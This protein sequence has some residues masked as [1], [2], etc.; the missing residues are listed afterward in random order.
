MVGAIGSSV[1]A[2]ASVS[3]YL[4]AGTA[5]ARAPAGGAGAAL[6]GGSGANGKPLSTADQTLLDKLKARDADVK[7]H[8]QAHRSAGGQYTGAPT[9]TYQKGPDGAN[10]AIGGEV[11]IDTSPVTRDPAATV[12][13]EEQVQRAALAPADPS[14]QDV[15][16]AAEAAAAIAQAEASKV[17]AATGQTADQGGDQTGP[18][19]GTG[20]AGRPDITGAAAT[21]ATAAQAGS[22]FSAR[23]ARGLA[24]YGSAA[25]LT[26]LAQPPARIALYA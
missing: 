5:S 11:S 12:A 21:T 6:A 20:S 25:G 13:K 3:Q 17:A 8:E 19:S 2:A 26:A 7:A 18:G 10:Y 4:A 1:G 9:Y 24:A 23:F 15:K 16:V 14:G 22:S